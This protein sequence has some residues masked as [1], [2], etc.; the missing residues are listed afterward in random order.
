MSDDARAQARDPHLE[1]SGTSNAST[2]SDDQ[3]TQGRAE[4]RVD[5]NQ[6]DLIVQLNNS[7][8]T[9]S[10]STAVS[11][12]DDNMAAAN[13]STHGLANDEISKPENS[14]ETI[15]DSSNIVTVSPETSS[16]SLEN[17]I[18]S[19]END[20]NSTLRQQSSGSH[21]LGKSFRREQLQ[22]ETRTRQNV[23]KEQ[24]TTSPTPTPTPT[25][26]PSNSAS[27]DQ[28]ADT[29]NS[30]TSQDHM[31]D[32]MADGT[33]VEQEE[34]DEHGWLS[35]PKNVIVFSRAGKPIYASGGD[36][37]RLSSIFGLLQAMLAKTDNRLKVIRAGP[38][39]VIVFAA[40]GPLLLAIASRGSDPVGYLQVQLEYIYA[41]ILVHF[42]LTSLLDTFRRKPGYDLR[43]MLGGAR[44]ELQGICDLAET[45]PS[46][47]LS[48][49]PMLAIPAEVRA[50]AVHI[51]SSARQ[52]S[53]L[54]A[55]LFAGDKVVAF[56][57]PRKHPLHA[58]DI[59][60]LMNFVHN[61]K[62]LRSQ[63][64]WTPLCL[65]AFNATGFLHAYAAYLSEHLCLLLLSA[66]ESLDQFHF[67]SESKASIANQLKNSGLGSRLE[68]ALQRG[69]IAPEACEA[70]ASV[71]LIYRSL[72]CDQY[73]ET[74]IANHAPLHATP[75]ARARLLKRYVNLSE[76]LHAHTRR[77]EIV[78]PI[79]G[80]TNHD[81]QSG[82][83]TQ[84]QQQQQQSDVSDYSAG[85][86][87]GHL[88]DVRETEAILA[89]VSPAQYEI[90][91][92]FHIFTSATQ[93]MTCV[94][95]FAGYVRAVRGEHFMIKPAVW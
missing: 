84:D 81:R 10:A 76:R 92:S 54:Y 21:K 32:H 89:I 80:Q 95:R 57:S 7:N 15:V 35:R 90:Y 65:P 5:D 43:S 26:P 33:S 18:P 49:I 29:E 70:A 9:P 68:A 77:L 11:T 82:Q 47:M 71:H 3:L 17:E 45:T 62:Q 59:L 73:F 88:W 30:L 28:S 6:V 94:A 27:A 52:S 1:A 8:H 69:D 40:R 93:A 78:S 20:A 58:S 64:T 53:L 61:A 12:A 31:K 22:V 23:Q 44:T 85:C 87:Q 4:T 75:A 41:Q 48:A 14:L 25:P 63:E 60:L 79:P 19:G 13:L 50:S 37:F 66:G 55:I 83:G 39:F 34:Y 38:N 67:C 72:K 24:D 42:T 74:K 86:E 46:L 16:L 56:I 36:E 91:A 2:H 51:L